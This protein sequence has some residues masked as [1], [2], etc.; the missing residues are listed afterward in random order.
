MSTVPRQIGFTGTTSFNL[1]NDIA[2]MFI[3]CARAAAQPEHRGAHRCNI[4]GARASVDEFVAAAAAALEAQGVSGSGITIDAD[5]PQLPFP[6][7]Y[8]ESTLRSLL[9]GA[10]KVPC[11]SVSDGIAETVAHFMKL[12]AAGR[13]HDRDLAA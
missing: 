6:D 8:D 4:A 2:D 9:G 13:L 3:M 1:V 12:H 7:T 10:D 5:G 11:K